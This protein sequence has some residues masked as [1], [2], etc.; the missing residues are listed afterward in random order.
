M[1]SCRTATPS[2]A[3]SYSW[4]DALTTGVV[5]LL[6][7]FAW[8]VLWRGLSTPD[9]HHL[10]HGTASPSMIHMGAWQFGLTYIAG[11]TLMTVAM[12]LPTSLPLV[13]LFRRM[14]S[15][16]ASAGALVGLLVSG[17][18]GVWALTG[19][20]LLMVHWLLRAGVERLA[21][22]GGAGWAVSATLLAGAGLYQFSGLKHA[23]LDKCRSPMSFLSAHWRGGT[24]W[25]QSIRL[26]AAH[27]LFCVGC[28][29]ALMLLMFVTGLGN[30]A[31]MM[32][33]GALMAME[34]NFRWGRR[35]A[36]PAGIVLLVAAGYAAGR[37]AGLI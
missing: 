32:A 26:G 6:S 20:G 7:M 37:S 24:E 27:G 21:W 22:P 17:Y 14:V 15:G 36:T 18:L 10:L 31:G 4:P 25:L 3:R 13:L 16:R 8:W 5:V 28:C 9:G 34:K 33:L 29:W 19:G 11:W 1:S 2:R 35:L 12:M 23:C 30:L